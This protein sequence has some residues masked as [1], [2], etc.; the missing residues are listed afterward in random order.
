MRSERWAGLSGLSIAIA[1]GGALLAFLLTR[2]FFDWRGNQFNSWQ[3]IYVELAYFALLPLVA[4]A[5]AWGSRAVVRKDRDTK[6]TLCHNPSPIGL[7]ATH[8]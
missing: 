4:G 2:P 1:V 7:I 5:A 8:Y 6:A 3:G